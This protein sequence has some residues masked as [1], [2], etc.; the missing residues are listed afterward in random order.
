MDG[1]GRVIPL[2]RPR[3]WIDDLM[4][5]SRNV[6]RVTF[7]RR[8]NLGPLVA[9]RRACSPRPV[10]AMLFLK[11]YG[12][13]AAVRPEL[14]R[15]YVPF[16]WPR[17]YEHPETIGRI[18]VERIV[19]GEAAVLFPSF[20][21]PERASIVDLQKRLDH[22]RREPVEQVGAFRRLLR[23]SRL[24]QPIR[25]V[26]WWW[27]LNRGASHRARALGTIGVSFT[28]GFGAHAVNLC[29]P[30]TAS[31]HC[32]PF[33]DSNSLDVF[34]TFDHRVLDGAPVARAMTHLEEMLN[35]AIVGELQSI[36]RVAA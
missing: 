10:W 27:G 22:M 33:D 32:G 16:P 31:L 17:L 26:C 34:L 9:A 23:L 21:A 24:P 14:R 15:L 35:E 11:A 8:M 5:E 20:V 25:R 29:A 30:A 12:L 13:V 1:Q 19:D 2:S 36:S 6:P 3:R 7:L 28:A 18:A 4:W